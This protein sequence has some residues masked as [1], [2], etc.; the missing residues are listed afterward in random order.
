MWT[1][2]FSSNGTPFYYNATHSKSCWK[3]PADAIVH[4]AEHL[5][6]PADTS[7]ESLE[8]GEVDTFISSV[9]DETKYRSSV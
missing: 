4:E 7:G 1:K 6:R 3:P 8:A 5:K 9:V 2:R